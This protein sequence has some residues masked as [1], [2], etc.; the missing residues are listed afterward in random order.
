MNIDT[1]AMV[2]AMFDG[3][4]QPIPFDRPTDSER[5]RVRVAIERHKYT[6]NERD[7]LRNPVNQEDEE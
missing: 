7:E 6:E 3:I 2:A 1:R 5:N 4:P